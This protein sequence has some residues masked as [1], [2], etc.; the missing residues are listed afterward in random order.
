ML[1]VVCCECGCVQTRC[2][3]S[4]RPFARSDFYLT[5]RTC[6]FCSTKELVRTTSTNQYYNKW[7]YYTVFSTERMIPLSCKLQLNNITS[8]LP[9]P[10]SPPP[11]Q[12]NSWS[13]YNEQTEERIK[14]QFTT[15]RL[16]SPRIPDNE[17]TVLHLLSFAGP[18]ILLSVYQTF[19]SFEHW[20][21]RLEYAFSIH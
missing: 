5:T 1:D 2:P 12:L 21:I 15:A 11:Q 6:T 8:Q 16:T 18:N 10:N 9:T 7:V 19:Q 3:F 17:S 20:R 13:L 14:F 4:A